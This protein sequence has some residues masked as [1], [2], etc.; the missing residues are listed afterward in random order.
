MAQCMLRMGATSSWND[1]APAMRLG[2]ADGLCGG[3]ALGAP[4]GWL[5][6]GRAEFGLVLDEDEISVVGG[7]APLAAASIELGDWLETVVAA[8]VGAPD[9]PDVGPG[10]PIVEPNGIAVEQA[11]IRALALSSRIKRMGRGMGSVPFLLH[12]IIVRTACNPLTNAA[13]TWA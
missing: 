13:G 3:D 2:V 4:E 11:V 12:S 5:L 9:A 10:E 1:T 6:G 8:G 7:L